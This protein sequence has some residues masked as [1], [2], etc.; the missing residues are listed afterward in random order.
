MPS[1]ARRLLPTLAV[2]GVAAAFLEEYVT[3]THVEEVIFPGKIN[4]N[5]VQ[6]IM[7]AA[8]TDAELSAC[9]SADVVLSACIASGYLD[10]AAPTASAKSCL[11]C[12]KG[13][14]LSDE[15]SSCSTYIATSF[16]TE[17][18]AFTTISLL[19]DI[20]ATGTCA[21]T[22]PTTPTGTSGTA[23]A[24]PPAGCTS[25]VSVYQSCTSK[26]PG[27]ATIAGSKMADCLCYDL[28]GKYNTRFDDYASSCAPFAKTAVPSEYSIISALGDFCEAFPPRTT[29]KGTGAFD[30][31]G[32]KA[33]TTAESASITVTVTAPASPASAPGGVA[34]PWAVGF[35]SL[36]LS[37]LGY[38]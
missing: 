5:A 28:L 15:Y 30:G 14:T 2:A 7:V 24:I 16:P 3:V 21:A 37:L 4:I 26:V 36:L 12:Y 38:I 18:E 17:T 31:I 29:A 13:L 32:T 1:I 6:G 19:N 11:C 33:S 20:C 10:D 25:F 35:A 23:T 9:A 34:V 8:V 22:T 27:W